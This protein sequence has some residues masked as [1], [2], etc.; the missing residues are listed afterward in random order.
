MLLLF[1]F[2]FQ[3]ATS[4]EELKEKL[5][6]TKKLY[7]IYFSPMGPT[8]VRIQTHNTPGEPVYTLKKII[9]DYRKKAM[10]CIE[11]DN[12]P[13]NIIYEVEDLTETHLKGLLSASPLF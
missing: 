7:F 9:R 5:L 2:L 3:S 11:D 4:T 6:P 10:N 8:H 12:I 13:F 1:F